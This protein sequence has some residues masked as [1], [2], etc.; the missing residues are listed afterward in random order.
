MTAPEQCIRLHGQTRGRT[1]GWVLAALAFTVAF[2]FIVAGSVAPDPLGLVISWGL[3]AFV[4]ICSVGVLRAIWYALAPR[5][6]VT[7]TPYPLVVGR[8]VR[9]AWDFDSER[10]RVRDLRI[11]ARFLGGRRDGRRFTGPVRVPLVTVDGT[12]ARHGSLEVELPSNLVPSRRSRPDPKTTTNQDLARGL[13][14][15]LI[16]GANWL[17]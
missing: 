7:L 3:W 14:S 6:E 10:G 12:R 2:R 9:V 16:P 17:R 4:A 1:I 13:P 15:K 11:E 8:P 5:L